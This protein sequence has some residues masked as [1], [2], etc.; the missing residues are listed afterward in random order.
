MDQ[1]PQPIKTQYRSASNSSNR[2]V[3]GS[4][5]YIT[6]KLLRK[7]FKKRKLDAKVDDPNMTDNSDGGV[8]LEKMEQ[9]DSVQYDLEQVADTVNQPFNTF[10]YPWVI[11]A[12][13]EWTFTNA[14]GGQTYATRVAP[15]EFDPDATPDE[16]KPLISKL[17]CC[18]TNYIL[19]CRCRFG[20]DRTARRAREEAE[21][22]RHANLCEEGLRCRLGDLGHCVW[23]T[24]NSTGKFCSEP[25]SRIGLK[26]R[27]DVDVDIFILPTG[28]SRES[29]FLCEQ[30]YGGEYRSC[31]ERRCSNHER[32]RR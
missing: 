25:M 14:R 30:D 28:P 7:V 24:T 8:P 12:Y 17:A 26:R 5:G 32:W 20:S 9:L 15:N 19:G 27:V 10:R 23:T 18:K 11:G 1:Q 29:F 13:P 16:V 2:S 21:T 22:S 4:C 31:R 3:C 6:K